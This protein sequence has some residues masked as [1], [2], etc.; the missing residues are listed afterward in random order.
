M[1]PGAKEEPGDQWWDASVDMSCIVPRLWQGSVL[2]GDTLAARGIDVV[3]LCARHLQLAAQ[4]LPGVQIIRAGMTD[5]DLSPHDWRTARD[6]GRGVVKAYRR[7]KRVLV[8]CRAGHNRSGLVMGLALADL[9]WLPMTGVVDHIR[10]HRGGALRNPSFV[11]ALY[12]LPDEKR[13]IAAPHAI[14]WPVRR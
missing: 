11:N 9:T 1:I 3:V 12:S 10:R 6:A 5:S 13:T 7:G 14:E 8:A 4:D 2:R